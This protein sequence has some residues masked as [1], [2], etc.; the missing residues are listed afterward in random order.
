M[1]PM[2]TTPRENEMTEM[3][4]RVA[5]AIVVA[6]AARERGSSVSVCEVAARAAIETMQDPTEVPDDGLG[7]AINR[8]EEL[9]KQIVIETAVFDDE[10]EPR[11]G[12]LVLHTPAG[13]YQFL[14]I[15]QV[16]NEL[17]QQLRDFIAGDAERLP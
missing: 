2:A 6:V 3:V 10:G 15:E 8:T 4:D 7:N 14:L 13:H 1:R 16:A 12:V 11:V 17:I 9:E 5:K